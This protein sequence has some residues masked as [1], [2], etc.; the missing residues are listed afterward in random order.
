MPARNLGGE[1]MSSLLVT[2]ALPNPPGK[3]RSASGTSNDQLNGEWVEF[4]NDDSQ[5][6]E[7]EPVSLIHQ[8]YDQ[9]CRTTGTDAVTGFKGALESGKSIRVHT[10]TG[11][12]FWDGD[13]FH[14]FLNR[15]NYIW[16]NRCGD[17]VTLQLGSAVIDMAAYGNNPP[18][19]ATLKRTPGT[20]WLA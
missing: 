11:T 12:G 7:L 6:F 10:G 13:V 9:Q 14:L 16:N 1:A 19:G 3:D 8:T 15:K 17:T 5:T 18:E 20:N 2:F 4:R